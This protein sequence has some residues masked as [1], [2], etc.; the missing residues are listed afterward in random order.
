MSLPAQLVAT[1][2]VHVPVDICT[3]SP[4]VDAIGRSGPCVNLA[5]GR[6]ALSRCAYCARARPRAQ[7]SMLCVSMTCA[8]ALCGTWLHESLLAGVFCDRSAA[9][10]LRQS[11]IVE[12]DAPKFL[13]WHSPQFQSAGL[14]KVRAGNTNGRKPETGIAFPLQ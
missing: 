2:N 13:A 9:V 3:A 5:L 7:P 11:G 8:S 1:S 14:V 6:R 4:L 12:Y 10:A